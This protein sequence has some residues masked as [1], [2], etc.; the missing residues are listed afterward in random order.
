MLVAGSSLLLLALL[1]AL[2]ANAGGASKMKGALRV[3]FW[4][5]IAMAATMGVG[6]LFDTPVQ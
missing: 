6:S 2:A 1:G 3:V 4:G 5:G